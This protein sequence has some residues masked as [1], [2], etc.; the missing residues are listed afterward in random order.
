MLFVKTLLYSTTYYVDNTNGDDSNSGLSEGDAW[1]S[2]FK[3]ENYSFQ[4]GDSI[5]LK[6]G[7][8]WH[9]RL[10]FSSSGSPGSP[11]YFGTYGTGS[12]PQINIMKEYSLVWTHDTGNIWYCSSLNDN[13]KRLLKDDVEIMDAAV[14]YFDELGTNIPDL[15]EWY[16]GK[17]D[18]NDSQEK[19][20]L[21]S[22]DDPNSH[23][24]TFPEHAYALEFFDKHYIDINQL[25][26]VG[27]S[28]ACITLYSC[29]YINLK[30][31]TVGN[32]AN[33]G[34]EITCY[35]PNG[36]DYQ[37]NEYINIDS[38]IIDTHYT[39]DYSGA[40]TQSGKSNRGPREGVLFRRKTQNCTLKNSLIKNYCHANINIFSPILNEQPVEGQ[41]LKNNKIHHNTITSPDLAYGGRIAIDGYC[42]DN[43]IFDNTIEFTSVQSQFNGHNNHIHHNIFKH[44]INSPLKSWKVGHAI[45]LQGYYSKVYGNIIENNLMIDCEAAGIFISGNNSDGDVTDNTIRNNTIYNCGS[46]YNDYGISVE[47]DFNTYTNDGN[48]FLN[49]LVY[50]ANTTQT[51][52]FYGSVMDIDGFNNQ[53]GTHSYEILDN[54]SGNPLFIDEQNNDYHIQDNSPCID[55][56]ITPLATEDFEGNPIPYGSSAD[57]GIYENQHSLAIDD[58]ISFKGFIDKKNVILFWKLSVESL[59]E[60][61]YMYVQRSYDLKKWDNLAS[62]T[63]SDSKFEYKY[64][65]TE[66]KKNFGVVYYRIMIM[67]INRI[68]KYSK[69]I[70]LKLNGRSN[71]YILYPNPAKNF[72]NLKFTNWI[73]GVLT[74]EIYNCTGSIAKKKNIPINLKTNFIHLDLTGKDAGIYIVKIITEKES[75]TS[76]FVLKK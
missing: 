62:I 37:K 21:Y 48:H 75:F 51:V 57:I 58:F 76:K 35:K 23:L 8:V 17:K 42:Y 41:E 18:S 74:I 63:F 36:N 26:F 5:L 10:L 13:P 38:C 16:W 29:S 2:L 22:T 49:N 68:M 46:D 24:F 9:E 28:L 70:S 69:I 61:S 11:I 52:Y 60:Q 64:V 20:Y 19:L 40:G 73:D 34:I 7:E 32:Y 4:P 56:G 39:F 55:S 53:N 1:K 25:E 33:Y 66:N 72:V 65:D 30:N 31:L 54:I 67:D 6:R 45:S 50:S 71:D 59:S 3:L 12:K 44:T 27:A 15:V 47:T 43:E 14:G